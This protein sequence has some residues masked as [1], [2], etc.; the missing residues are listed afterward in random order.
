MKEQDHQ[1][2]QQRLTAPYAPKM[3][4]TGSE[5]MVEKKINTPSTMGIPTIPSALAEEVTTQES[6]GL[7][8][9]IL[10]LCVA[11]NLL[12][13]GLLQLLF[14]D[15]GFLRLEWNSSYWFLY[16]LGALPLFYLGLKR[17]SKE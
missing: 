4:K 15:R 7:F 2:L 10:L 14:S 6:R 3:N 12:T 9:P 1:S 16:C 5:S 8:L 11:G 13:I 17:A